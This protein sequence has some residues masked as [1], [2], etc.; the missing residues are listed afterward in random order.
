VVNFSC[1]GHH[2][3]GAPGELVLVSFGGGCVQHW[4]A[5]TR[6]MYSLNTLVWAAAVAVATELSGEFVCFKSVHLRAEFP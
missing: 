4:E 5:Q 2:Q 6:G 3:E 1:S